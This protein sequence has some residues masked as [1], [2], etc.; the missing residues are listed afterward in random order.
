MR[1]PGN[2]GSLGPCVLTHTKTTPKKAYERYQ[3]H[4]M[5]PHTDL[6][7]SGSAQM[8]PNGQSAP[9]SDTTP[10]L[11]TLSSFFFLQQNGEAIFRRRH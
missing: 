8:C 5:E 7:P 2:R 6:G 4:L 3:G 1:P 9:D 11:T 10:V